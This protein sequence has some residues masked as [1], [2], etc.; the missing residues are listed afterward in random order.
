[1]SKSHPILFKGEMI[2][3]I[4]A[5]GQAGED[6]GVLQMILSSDI[7]SKNH[8]SHRTSD[9]KDEW[10][11]PSIILE[12]LGHFD[13]DPCACASH[14]N[15][16]ARSSHVGNGL[17]QSWGDPDFSRVFCNPP[18][19]DWQKWLEA[20]AM[21]KNATA[22]IFARTGTRAFQR[23]VFQKANS[24]LF[25]RGKLNFLKADLSCP[26]SA[27]AYSV[28]VAYDQRNSQI[29]K[30][31]NIPGVWLPMIGKETGVIKNA[32]LDL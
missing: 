29:L 21:H 7:K 11:T 32:E 17:R 27:T 14:P 6:S 4:L 8:F 22:L 10:L 12:A 9:G 15:R 1:M 2:R 24:I 31:C 20:C 26:S 19:S 5:G 23:L 16:C 30:K 18:Y 25:I 28:L 3:E 13:L